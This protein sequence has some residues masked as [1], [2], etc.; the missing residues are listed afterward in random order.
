MSPACIRFSLSLSNIWSCSP[1]QMNRTVS[2]SSKQMDHVR[3]E[4]HAAF[5]GNELLKG[6]LLPLLRRAR[7]K[8]LVPG[9]IAEENHNRTQSVLRNQIHRH[10][11]GVNLLLEATELP[12]SEDR[13]LF[14]L[15]VLT[16][17]QSFPVKAKQC[18]APTQ[19]EE[20]ASM[21]VHF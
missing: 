11:R 2:T 16:L 8:G 5:K 9:F 12:H 21:H 15:S 14:T 4:K 6:S 10:V 19:E 1:A 7:L 20:N 3:R 17:H 18:D 13:K